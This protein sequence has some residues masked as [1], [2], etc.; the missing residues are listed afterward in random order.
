MTAP[1]LQDSLDRLAHLAT[2]KGHDFWS[3]SALRLDNLAYA[4]TLV[5]WFAEAGYPQPGIAAAGPNVQ[6]EWKIHPSELEIEISS[7]DRV[8]IMLVTS[9]NDDTTPGNVK[10]AIGQALATVFGEQA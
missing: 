6:L 10:A 7:R 4:E 1:T 9:H 3:G 8:E 5:R 2:L